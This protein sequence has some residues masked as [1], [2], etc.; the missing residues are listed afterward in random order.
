ML[1]YSM[2]IN[3]VQTEFKLMGTHPYYELNYPMEPECSYQVNTHVRYHI[4]FNEFTC[5]KR[6]QIQNGTCH[7][8]TWEFSHRP[9]DPSFGFVT[10]HHF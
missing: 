4:P 3:I 1:G 7:T 6:G 9:N 2:D 8:Y 5:L 10:R